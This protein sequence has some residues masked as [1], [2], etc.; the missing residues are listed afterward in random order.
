[1]YLAVPNFYQM[2]KIVLLFFV[3]IFFTTLCSAQLTGDTIVVSTFNYGQTYGSGIRDTMIPFPNNANVTYE[4]I[5]MLYNMRCKNGLISPAVSGQTNIGCGEWDYSCNTYITDSSKTDSVL[6]K[7]PSHIISGFTGTTYNYTTQPT[8]TYYQYQQQQVTYTSTISETT[9]VLGTGTTSTNQVL[10]AQQQN[11]KTQFLYTSSELTAAGLTAGTITGLRLHVINAGGTLQFLKIRIK[12]TVQTVLNAS[13]VELTGFTEVYFLN[14]LLANGMNQ[15]NFYNNYTW[16]G[17]DNLIVEYSFSNTTTGTASVLMSDTTTNI[18]GLVS[19]GNDYSFVCSGSNKI[20]LGAANFSNFSNQLSIAFWSNGNTNILPSNTS[21]LYATNAQNHRQANVHLPWSNGSIYWDCGSGGTYDRINKQ[22]VT[23]EYEGVW[24]Y[25]TFTKNTTTGIMNIYLNGVLWHTGSA[26]TIPIQISQFMLGGDPA[27]AN[28]Y[29][30]KID[31]LTLWNTELS[32]ATIQQW[33]YRRINN[34]HPNYNNLIAY[35][36]LNEGSG[37]VCTDYSV[38]PSSASV[39]GIGMWEQTKGKNIF[40]EFEETNNRPMT[41]FVQGVYT[42]STTQ[43]T[44]MDSVQNAM[45]RVYSFTINNNVVTPVDTNDYYQATNSIVYDGDADT[46]ITSIPIAATDSIN[47]TQLNY[48]Q[49]SPSKFQIMSFVTPYGI[50]LDLGMAGKTWTFDVTDYAP[51]LKGTK[52]MTMD[53]GGQWQ[54]DMD[55]KFLFIV[56]TPPRTVKDIYNIWKVENS[57]YTNILNNTK[58]EPRA[59][60]LDPTAQQFKLRS[61]ITGHGQ[62]GEFIPQNHWINI[63][64]GAPEYSWQVWKPCASNPVFPQGGT[65]IYDRAGWCPGMATDTK[66][67]NLNTYVSAGQT[68]TMDYGIDTATGSSN[69]WVS[70]QLVSYGGANFTT[71]A[72]I[73]DVKNPSKK[74]EYARTNSICKNPIVLIQNTGSTTLQSVEIEY[75][76]NG[77]TQHETYTWTGTLSFL[78]KV[79]VQLPSNNSLWSGLSGTAT[80]VFHAKIKKANTVI[81]DYSYNNTYHSDFSIT[82]VLPSTFILLLKT[83]NAATETMYEILDENNTQVLVRN[84]LSNNTIYRDTMHLNS[85]CYSLIINDSDEDG[86]NFFAN[87]DGSGSAFIKNATGANLVTLKTDFGKSLI[88]NFT[89]DYPLS[90]EQLYNSEVIEIF[91][92]PAK[93]EFTIETKNSTIRNFELLNAVG[94][95]IKVP[96]KNTNGILRCNASVLS[97]GVYYVH[98]TTS[99]NNVLTKK[100]VVE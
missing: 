41:T 35:Y 74:I 38:A 58:F 51:I 10:N 46:V 87:S 94:Q 13:T 100:V 39:S 47:I 45:Q 36:P 81:D 91:P 16:N 78:E 69:Y 61:A 71:D 63:Q 84:G 40:K 29:F 99:A 68:V 62:E 83:N 48:Y 2:K 44:V 19:S 86:L 37:S 65:W 98:I 88:Y 85:G 15:F 79:E 42:Q 89:I 26:K 93:N 32:A 18:S 33:M 4:K 20:N 73:V 23:N 70:N 90:Y 53:A 64:G 49:F 92:N 8:Y 24:N 25:W 52:R 5:L 56:G 22:A 76:I 3:T 66:E 7:H 59:I 34:T 75:W 14:T 17:T 57:G 60:T 21:I 95:T 72:A 27:N 31:D 1:M 55:I 80:N 9:A 96:Y 28:P 6:A 11:A 50:N 12:P 54:E 82:S 67:L 97:K 30:G 77:A 43:S